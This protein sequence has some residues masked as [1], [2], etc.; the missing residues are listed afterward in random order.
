MASPSRLRPGRL[1]DGHTMND[2][3]RR[4]STENKKNR[5]FC[6]SCRC[7][8]ASTTGQL[9]CITLINDGYPELT[10]AGAEKSNAR[11]LQSKQNGD[12]FEL[13]MRKRMRI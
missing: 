7:P 6:Q 8:D 1:Q 5:Q 3:V 4:K 2:C 10:V 11:R 9:H 12:E 13:G